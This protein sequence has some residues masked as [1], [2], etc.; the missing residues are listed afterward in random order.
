MLEFLKWHVGRFLRDQG[1]NFAILSAVAMF[2]VLVAI[3]VAIDYTNASFTAEKMQVALDSATLVAVRLYG[4][5]HSEAEATS[6]ANDMF[7]ANFT[8]AAGRSLQIDYSL[9]GQQATATADY[10]FNYHP[11]FL[12]RSSFPISRQSSTVYQAGK[13]ACILALDPT[14]DR[15][16]EVSGNSSVD[17][18]LCAITANSRSDKAI[19]VGGSATLKSECLYTP[20]K[21][22]ASPSKIDLACDKPN[23]GTAAAVDPFVSRAIPKAGSLVDLKN[24]ASGELTPGTYDGLAIKGNVKLQPGDYIIDGGQLSFTGQSVI[25]GARVTFFLLNGAEIDI[26]GGST[27]NLTA[28]TSGPWAGFSIV[29]D[30]SNTASA[31]INGNSN[32]KLNGIIYMPAAKEIRY[33]GNGTTSG[34]CVRIIAQ[35]IKMTGNSKFKLDCKSELANNEINNAGAVRLVK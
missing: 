21:V 10:A 20:G 9:A 29:A 17:T 4:E 11:V 28:P 23:E 30:R 35:T 22:S 3:S 6:L 34:E 19:Y 25:T 8:D 12:K 24:K 5:G 2:P 26:H 1:G 18:S 13:E 27:F 16:F 14:A 33:S 15:A 7:Y 31:V 32:S